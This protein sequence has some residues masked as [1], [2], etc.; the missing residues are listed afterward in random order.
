MCFFLYLIYIFLYSVVIQQTLQSTR[1]SYYIGEL[2]YENE[3]SK[4]HPTDSYHYE[5]GRILGD[6]RA[7]E[8]VHNRETQS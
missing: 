5:I 6:N 8:R 4:K 2:V 3:V 1:Y 7:G